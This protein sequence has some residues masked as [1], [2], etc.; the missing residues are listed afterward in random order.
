MTSLQNDIL[1]IGCIIWREQ[2]NANSVNHV[3][4]LWGLLQL[5]FG[6]VEWWDQM[7]WD[8]ENTYSLEL[9]GLSS[10]RSKRSLR[11]RWLIFEVANKK[12]QQ[13]SGCFVMIKDYDDF[14]GH[15]KHFSNWRVHFEEI[16]NYTRIVKVNLS[17][18][19]HRL[20]SHCGEPARGG[21]YQQ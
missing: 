10:D 11:R 9:R 1:E 16:L 17:R 2:V 8:L 20:H 21:G 3:A 19:L 6:Y 4:L 18:L 13:Q 15:H 7:L 14:S 12:L 5:R